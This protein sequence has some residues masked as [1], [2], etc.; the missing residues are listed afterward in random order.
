MYISFFFTLSSQEKK[1][2]DI[3]SLWQ[4]TVHLVLYFFCCCFFPDPGRVLWYGLDQIH[5]GVLHQGPG[6]GVPP[7]H[8]GEQRLRDVVALGQDG[9]GPRNALG[10]QPP[11]GVRHD[12][13]THAAVT[14]VNN[15]FIFRVPGGLMILPVSFGVT[16]SIARLNPLHTRPLLEPC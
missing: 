4:R 3:S 15:C 8:P 12:A 11:G 10:R 16:G 1:L 13:A 14:Q 6:A 2:Y 5:H 9:R 7:S